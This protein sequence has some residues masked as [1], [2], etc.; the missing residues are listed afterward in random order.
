MQ[1]PLQA[2]CQYVQRTHNRRHNRDVYCCK[3]LKESARDFPMQVKIY[4]VQILDVLEELAKVMADF[5]ETTRAMSLVLA[6]WLL[7]S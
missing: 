6:R 4:K 3:L 1:K 2:A 7:M 5:E